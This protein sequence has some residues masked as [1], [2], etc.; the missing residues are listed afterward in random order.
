M[1]HPQKSFAHLII[2]DL[3]LFTDQSHTHYTHVYTLST[4]A[5]LYNYTLSP[6]SAKDAT[7]QVIPPVT[8]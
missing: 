2:S 3:L 8:G 5:R 6:A 7:Q 4:S 1:I